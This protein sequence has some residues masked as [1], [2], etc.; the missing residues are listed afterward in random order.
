MQAG[1]GGGV[2][3]L[4]AQDDATIETNDSEIKVSAER[5]VIEAPSGAVVVGVC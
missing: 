1:S 4:L 2:V 3:L 5:W